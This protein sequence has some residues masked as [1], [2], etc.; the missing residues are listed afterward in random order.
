MLRKETEEQKRKVKS[1]RVDSRPSITAQ[2]ISFCIGERRMILRM[3]KILQL[4]KEQILLPVVLAW[5][6]VSSS[7]RSSLLAKV[8]VVAQLEC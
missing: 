4:I 5:L 1:S 7:S 6:K 8:I 2:P 3:K